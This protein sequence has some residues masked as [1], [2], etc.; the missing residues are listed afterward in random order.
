[1]KFFKRAG[2][3]IS[4]TFLAVSSLMAIN[5]GTALAAGPFTCTWTGG[6]VDSNFSTSANW[7][8]CNGAA[9]AVGDNDDL[10]FDET[11][12]IVF[13]A[14]NDLVGASFNSITFQGSGSSFAID[15]N[16]FTLTGGIINNAFD[17]QSIANDM[18]ISGAQTMNVA[19]GDISLDGSLSGS[20]NLAVQ[21]N[22]VLF[23]GGN[24]STY[25]GSIDI[26]TGQLWPA[27]LT[28][29]GSSA[30]STTVES[31]SILNFTVSGTVAEPL[32]LAGEGDGSTF[33]NYAIGHYNSGTGGATLTLS[34]NITLTAD[35]K[36]APGTFRS[37]KMVLTGSISGAHSIGVAQGQYGDLVIQSPS[38]S[39]QTA[40][41][42]YQAPAVTITISNSQ[43]FPVSV[44]MNETYVIDGTRSSVFVGDGGTLKGTGTVADVD[45]EKGGIVAPGHSPGCLNTGDLAMAGTYQ[46]EIGGTTAC[47]G[48]DQLNVTGTVDLTG[49]TLTTSLYNNYKPAAGESYTIIKND[50]SDAVT[51]TFSGLAEGATFNLNGYVFQVTYKG[52]DGN[53]VVLSVKSVPATPDTGF[54]Y[55]GT[56]P[57]ITLL[58]TSLAAGGILAIA[59]QNRK[60]SAKVRR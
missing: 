11:T 32:I 19:S 15:G 46:A 55:L 18:V 27:T 2:S 3:F 60:I 28:A 26:V 1:M 36:V 58:G 57:L 31:G 47:S 56:H 4:A 53:D 45:V 24:N 40:N 52:G 41:G 23:L 34:G 59:R 5:L 13:S 38:N 49:A 48:Y 29:L 16:S 10:I 33:T 14:T 22:G 7:S 17:L 12:A 50:G 21:G 44:L 42:T 43:N 9:P 35:T 37:D 54:G 30:G 51:G 20:G 8:G 6:G 25:S 39:S